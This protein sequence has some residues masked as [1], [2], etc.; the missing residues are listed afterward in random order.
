MEK[1]EVSSLCENCGCD[2]PEIEAHE[3]ESCGDVLCPEC[4]CESC[5]RDIDEYWKQLAEDVQGEQNRR[6]RDMR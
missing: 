6:L 1:D 3:C 2:F 4:I 5:E